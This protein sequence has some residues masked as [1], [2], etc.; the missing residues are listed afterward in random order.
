MGIRWRSAAC[1]VLLGLAAGVAAVVE[2]E[3]QP[4]AVAT[5][6]PARADGWRQLELPL[7]GMGA[8]PAAR[9][10]VA[11]SPDTAAVAALPLAGAGPGRLWV[12]THEGGVSS[13]RAR[14]VPVALDGT[15]VEVGQGLAVEGRTLVVGSPEAEEGAGVVW[16]VRDTSAD[17]DWSSVKATR[18]QQPRPFP[19]AHFGHSVAL[20]GRVAVVGAPLDGSN[21]HAVGSV[22]VVRDRSHAGNWSAVEVGSVWPGGVNVDD[23]LG[24]AVAVDGRTVAV[25]MPL[26][27]TF[28]PSGG[29]AFVLRDVDLVGGFRRWRTVRLQPAGVRFYEG[30]G[31]AVAVS[32][33][34]L[35]VGG[36]GAVRVFRDTS[37]AGDWTGVSQYLVRPDGVGASFGSAVAT[38]GGV[39]LVGEPDANRAGTLS[40]AVWSVE[41]PV[42]EEPQ[43]VVDVS[44]VGRG[45]FERVGHTVAMAGDLAV[46]G[47]WRRGPSETPSAGAWLLMPAVFVTDFE[48]GTTASWGSSTEPTPTPTPR[49]K[50]RR[51]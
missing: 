20:S 3:G 14:T 36:Q 43:R 18:V 12:V 1:F 41:L 6:A 15:G 7:G 42:G 35:V 48:T 30:L 46:V 19:G 34:T 21:W 38:N 16:L 47:G 45:R 51:R 5:P 17:G 11:A 49:P 50:R 13:P 4:V 28:A 44:P 23:R 27:D 33:R 25:G 32:G 31:R 10:V 22:W 26:K 29:S 40:G 2:G 24:A 9:M 39:V 8:G 37:A